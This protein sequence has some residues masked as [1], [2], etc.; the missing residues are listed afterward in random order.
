MSEQRDVV[1]REFRAQKTVLDE[2]TAFVEGACA[3]LGYP[4]DHF[5]KLE[6]CIE[7]V[8]VNICSYAYPDGPG[9]GTVRV[10]VSPAEDGIAICF[11]DGGI[12]FDPLA[13]EVGDLAERARK[14]TVGGLGIHLVRKFMD[15]VS[16][17]RSDG[18][19]WLTM[20]KRI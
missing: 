15:D 14:R 5:F 20:V 10:S 8:F 13:H 4:R 16:Y 9:S 12:A 7:E 18:E 6:M 3:S 11:V 2:V 1:E 19:N 17:E